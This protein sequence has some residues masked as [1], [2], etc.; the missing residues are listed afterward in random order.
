VDAPGG[1][2]RGGRKAAGGEEFRDAGSRD[3][4]AGA[5][6]W[7]AGCARSGGRQRAE[8]CGQARR[9]RERRDLGGGLRE[10]RK[11]A[12]KFGLRANAKAARVL[13]IRQ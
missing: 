3:G 9:R 7:A 2:L 10:K 11:T 8:S 6:I 4:G 12:G 1:G 5:A 13:R